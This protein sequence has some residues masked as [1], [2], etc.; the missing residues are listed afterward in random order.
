M[1]DDANTPPEP[2]PEYAKLVCELRDLVRR[3]ETV[4]KAEAARRA[5]VEVMRHASE[6]FAKGEITGAELTRLHAVR[7]RLDALVP[8]PG[9][10]PP[11]LDRSELRP[12]EGEGE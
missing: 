6:M 11:A 10:L 5:G 4:A 3:Q 9:D 7:L 12:I 8:L 2:R 1:N